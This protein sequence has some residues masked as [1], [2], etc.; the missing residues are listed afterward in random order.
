M[1]RLAVG[2][3]V[4]CLGVLGCGRLRFDVLEDA[5]GTNVDGAADAVALPITW[6]Q[7]MGFAVGGKAVLPISFGSDLGAGDVIVLGFDW[8]G[9]ATLSS[10]VDTRGNTYHVVESGPGATA[11]DVVL[12]YAINGA[13]GPD[14][15]TVTVSDA[16]NTFFEAHLLSYAGLDPVDP[17]D[18]ANVATGMSNNNVDGA[19]TLL[20]TSSLDELVFGFCAVGGTV[21]AGTGFTFRDGFAGDLTEDEIVTTVGAHVVTATVNGTWTM[22][23]A[24][25]RGRLA[26]RV[27]NVTALHREQRR[28]NASTRSATHGECMNNSALAFVLAMSVTGCLGLTQATYSSGTF[29]SPAASGAQLAHPTVDSAREVTRLLEIRDYALI[30]TRPNSPNGQ[31]LLKFSKSSRALAAQRNDDQA[32]HASDV[33]SVI[34]VWVTPA[35]PSS[36]TVSLYGKP[37]LAGQEPCTPDSPGL[38]CQQV[39]VDPDFVAVHMSGQ[40]E[41]DAIHGVLSELA[42]EGYI[43]GALPASATAPALIVTPPDAACIAKRKEILTEASKLATGDERAKVIETAPSC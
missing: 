35:G 14:A 31:L 11:F 13:A 32:M 15:V 17:F 8:D 1:H 38:P 24:A 37:T 39:E 22:V 16:T 18:V 20:V 4:G 23:A 9:G 27:T 34:Y 6:A 30:D 29:L 5:G 26:R 2:L 36:S 19:S 42:L 41:A 21:S 3:A 7:D 40:V 25:F 43:G 12:A 10:I 28:R 33:G